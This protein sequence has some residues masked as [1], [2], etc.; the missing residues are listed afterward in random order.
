LNWEAFCYLGLLR[1]PEQ[2]H[3]AL[4]LLP[5]EQ[6]AEAM[7]FLESVKDLPPPELVARWSRLREAEYAAMRRVAQARSGIRLD[8]LPPALRGWY[9]TCLA[10]RNGQQDS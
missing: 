5:E 7:S 2:L 1:F 10:D 3:S 9:I 6:K 4:A 8:E